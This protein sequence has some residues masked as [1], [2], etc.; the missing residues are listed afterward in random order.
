MLEWKCQRSAISNVKDVCHK[1]YR[2][3]GADDDGRRQSSMTAWRT[4]TVSTLGSTRRAEAVGTLLVAQWRGLVRGAVLSAGI[5]RRQGLVT[6]VGE[7][8]GG[9][10]GC[11]VG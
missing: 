11:R 8:R 3:T 1:T 10:R 9:G 7:V 5:V 4:S 6:G 2:S